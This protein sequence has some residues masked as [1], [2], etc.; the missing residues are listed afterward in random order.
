MK[1]PAGVSEDDFTAALTAFAGVVGKEW[2][3]TTDDD[4]ALYRDPYS[5]FWG[6]AEE[7]WAS[8]AAAPTSTDEVIALVKIANRFRIPIYP[9][10]TGRNL[11]YGGPAPAMAGCVV[12][13]LKRMNRIL[14]IDERNAYAVVEPGV[15]YFD[16]YNAIQE[17]GAKLWIDC[18]M[19][20]WGALIGNALDGGIGLTL[21][22][23]RAHF[24][25]H[26]GIEA[27]L[28]NGQLIRT[29]MGAMPTAK[30]WQQFKPG[31]GPRLDGLF[32]QSNFGIVTKMGFWL[33]P[34]PEKYATGVVTVP[35]YRDITPLIDT[36]SRLE[37]SRI[38]QGL[39]SIASP[40][41]GTGVFVIQ[42]DAPSSEKDPE[43]QALLNSPDDLDMDRL[44]SAGRRLNAPFW[45]CEFNFYGPRK[46]IEAQWSCVCDALSSIKG[47]SFHLNEISP[48]PLDKKSVDALPETATFGI[49][50]LRNFDLGPVPPSYDGHDVVGHVF[51][52]PIVPRNGEVALEALAVF[53]RIFRKYQLPFPPLQFPRSVF[54]R[55]LLMEMGL[56]VTRSPVVNKKVR[57]MHAELVQTATDHG[58]GAYRTATAFYDM[59]MDTYSF[60]D[61][62]LRTTLDTIK[63]ALDPN[64][65]VSPGRYSIWPR[66][67]RGKRRTTPV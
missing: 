47:A 49:P 41:V 20:G 42:G 14:E 10:S 5:I 53:T 26:C 52:S 39:W 44:E 54:E 56:P 1:L 65:I 18:A 38:V 12:F 57:A 61:H 59:V 34:A 50:T 60:N 33:M 9:I 24:D 3:F 28:P 13:D 15:S 63:D 31:F 2:L 6:E 11:G 29:G 58:W 48:L 16:L 36:I 22:P 43:I 35:G 46:L 51:F 25:A 19:P 21:A 55:S 4:L 27:V 66:H 67:L 40:V 7:S 30:T 45:S 62:A 17:R 37:N 23:Y 32:K 8:A 64:G